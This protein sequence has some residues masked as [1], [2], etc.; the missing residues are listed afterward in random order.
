MERRHYASDLTDRQWQKIQPLLP[1]PHRVGARQRVDRRAILNG[2]LYVN[3]TGCQWRAMP[4]D[5]PNW[6]TVYGVFRLW[7]MHGVWS[8]V[9]DQLREQ[10]RVAD[11]REATPSAAIVDSQSVKTTEV[12]GERGY[13]GGK[14]VTGRKRHLVVDTLGLILAVVVHSAGVPDYDGARR[15][16]DRMRGMFARLQLIWADSAYGKC[17]LPEW[18]KTQFGWILQTI[19]R[20]VQAVGFV[21]LPKRWIV[22]RTFGWLGRY[23]RHSKDYERI[24]VSSETMIHISMIHLMSRRLAAKKSPATN[25]KPRL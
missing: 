24:T 15:V 5:L 12:G 16:L 23:R 9:H 25:A 8:N 11:G 14:K 1:K 18:V 19:L 7:Q 21:L 17:G 2:I 4:H 20:P 22:E 6:N 3:R 10:V 13:D